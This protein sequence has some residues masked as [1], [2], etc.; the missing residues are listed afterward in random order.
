MVV[1]SYYDEDSR[2]RR[3]AE[4]LVASGRDVDVF[5]LRRPTDPPQGT[6]K[7]VHIHRLDVQRHQGAGLGTYL[8]EYVS[9]GV[10]A[11]WSLVRAQRRRGYGLIQVHSLPDFLAFAAFPLRLAGVPLILDLHEAMP[12]F[13]RSRFPRASNPLAHRLLLVQERLS[14]AISSAA[15][16]VNPAMADRLIGLGVAPSKVHIV[17]NRPSLGLFDADRYPARAFAE[18]GIVRLVY[19][20]A[21]TPTYELDVV[22]RAIAELRASRPDLALQLDLYGRGDA[23]PTLRSLVE[24]LGIEACVMFRGRI[25]LDDVPAAL[26]G[27]DIGLAPTRR[28]A[29]TDFSL[30]TKTFEYAA[31]GKPVVA[32]R[33]PMVVETFPTGTIR[34]YE[35]GDAASLAA[36]IARLIDDPAARVAATAATQRFVRDRSWERESVDYL[37]LVESLA[38]A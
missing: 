15:I 8:R 38:R 22:L 20:G 33:L 36:E 14:I 10:R 18:D 34:V 13:F 26:A 17:V 27:A 32:S 28:D 29:F 3:E 19:A 7:G 12:E 6:L 21:L 30:S 24:T 16:T 4:A 1:H 35:P 23:E 5:G 9:F 37:R 11:C 2:V 25:P 31:M